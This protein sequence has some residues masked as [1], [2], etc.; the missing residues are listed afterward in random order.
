M[1]APLMPTTVCV[2]LP[3]LTP[4]K[5]KLGGLTGVY[6]WTGGKPIDSTFSNTQQTQPYSPYCYHLQNPTKAHKQMAA[7]ISINCH[8]ETDLRPFS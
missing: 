1:S 4:M 2:P 6:P 7:K 5:L 8:G 3:P